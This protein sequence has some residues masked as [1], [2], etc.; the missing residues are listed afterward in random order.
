MI[1]SRRQ[2]IVIGAALVLAVGVGAVVVLGTRAPL[3]EVCDGVSRGTG[4]C[5]PDQPEF[6]ADTC[7]GVAR[8]FGIQLEERSLPIMDGPA[9]VNGEGRAVRLL[10]LNGLMTARV[11][12]Y[13]R[14]AGLVDDCGTDEF[15]IAAEAE[16]SD[17][18]KRRAGEYLY[19]GQ[20]RPYTEWR[21]ELRQFLSVIDQDED[22]PIQTP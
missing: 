18:F 3:P 13:L 2:L 15:L 22:V 17:D 7:A 10:H 9:V 5:D 8:E 19:D 11:D 14:R 20:S 21:A 6:T 4:G 16:F 1:M 12:R